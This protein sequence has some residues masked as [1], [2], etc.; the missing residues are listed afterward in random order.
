MQV[1]ETVGIVSKFKMLSSS[2]S[3]VTLFKKIQTILNNIEVSCV[4]EACNTVRFR[5]TCVLGILSSLK[6]CQCLSMDFEMLLPLGC[7]NRDLSVCTVQSSLSARESWE[8][9]GGP[10]LHRF[11]RC[12]SDNAGKHVSAAWLACR[13][14]AYELMT[15]HTPEQNPVSERA[16]HNANWDYLV[17]TVWREHARHVLA[18]LTLKVATII[19]TTLL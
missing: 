17:A 13:G 10:A 15:R 7:F 19:S 12:R 14:I 8:P 3:I 2:N 18:V 5:W 1:V 6:Q 9:N 11:Q 16:E 4:T